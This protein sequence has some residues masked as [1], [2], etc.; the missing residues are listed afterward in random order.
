MFEDL[1][2]TVTPV[3]HVLVATLYSG[4]PHYVA[5]F[6]ATTTTVHAF[7]SPSY[8]MPFYMYV[9]YIIHFV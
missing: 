3:L 9:T 1:C 4:P 7:I 6:F 5:K 8:K 2:I